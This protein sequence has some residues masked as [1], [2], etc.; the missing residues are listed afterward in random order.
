MSRPSRLARRI[1]GLV[2]AALVATAALTACGTAQTATSGNGP[3]ATV[4][5]DSQK[6][7]V[8]NPLRVAYF[9]A[10]STN[11]YL[12]A[13]KKSIEGSIGEI[14][15][16]S[17]TSFDGKFDAQTQIN[18]VQNALASK[19]FNAFIIDPLD[20]NLMCNPL[21]KS[22]PAAGVVVVVIAAPLCG[23]ISKPVQDQYAPGTLAYLGGTDTSAYFEKF[24]EY[25]AEQNPGPQKV[26]VLTGPALFGV[27]INVDTALKAVQQKYP[28]FKVVA[29]AATDYS[30][31]QGQQKT[32]SMV[33]ANPDATLLF[34]DYSDITR[35]AVTALK[36]AG[37]LDQ[38]KV[39]DKGGSS[40]VVDAM[41]NGE[42]V[43]TS[44]YY[45]TSNG[46]AAVDLL[47]KAFDG[48]ETPRF[49]A[50]DGAPVPPGADEETGLVVI[51]QSNL[52]SYQAE[53]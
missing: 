33:Q 10:G 21:T 8:K 26:L 32:Q 20:G 14:D 19:K 6:L 39:Y 9:A 28:D 11:S 52:S 15:G 50:N 18:Q 27:T 34:T 47:K 1:A 45:P 23:R 24:F 40:W 38:I 31:L 5:V 48:Q 35:G 22:A 3:S 2:L 37:K 7:T 4:D 36:S 30:V 53:Y 46:A 44:G 17:V 43:A 49:V 41:K 29:E 25:M 51:D 12:A 42:V 16:A 13:L